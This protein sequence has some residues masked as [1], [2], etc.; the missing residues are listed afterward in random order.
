MFKWTVCASLSLLLAT[1]AA[2]GA[3]KGDRKSGPWAGSYQDA[4]VT[5]ALKA[6]P[7]GGYEGTILFQGQSFPLT[8]RGDADQLSG[9]FRSEDGSFDFTAARHGDTVNLATGGKTYELK[10]TGVNPLGGKSSAVNPLAAAATSPAR[11]ASG[12]A[13]GGALKGYS[14]ALSTDAGK[15]LVA[16]KAEAKSV[17]T[18]LGS[19]LQD[20][21]RTPL[22]TRT[23]RRCSPLPLR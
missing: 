13:S 12:G 1:M 18:A 19:T 20:L 15:K 3:D 16:H 21:S 8:A 9:A 4:Q 17:P 10:R 5:L 14:V 7:D 2:L 23:G 11:E 6:R 22:S